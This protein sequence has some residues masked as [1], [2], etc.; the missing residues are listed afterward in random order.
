MSVLQ[1]LL[2]LGEATQKLYIMSDNFE[3]SKYYQLEEELKPFA[4]AMGKAADAIL[5]QDVSNYPIFVVHQYEVDIGIP[6]LVKGPEGPGWSVN[7]STLEELATKKIIEMSRVDNF[8]KV[9]KN[10]EAYLCLFVLSE[11]GANFIFIPRN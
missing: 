3:R 6:L 5:D 2:I 7:A 8:R 10:P 1:V 4:E 11:L 9:Y